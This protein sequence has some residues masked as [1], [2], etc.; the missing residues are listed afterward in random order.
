MSKSKKALLW[1]L[2]WPVLLLII[3]IHPKTEKFY[4]IT[5]T[6]I[7]LVSCAIIF[8]ALPQKPKRAAALPR[9]TAELLIRLKPTPTIYELSLADIKLTEIAHRP[10]RTPEPVHYNHL[11]G[12]VPSDTSNTYGSSCSIKGNPDSMI[13]HCKNGA[14]YDR[15]QNNIEWFCSPAQA[16][17][18]GYRPAENM[19]GCIY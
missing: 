14:S 16:E 15:L 5:L 6:L 7:L 13:Y 11:R 9:P 12:S 4:R 18:A 17:A 19:T 2:L 10:T 8:F 3:I 1:L